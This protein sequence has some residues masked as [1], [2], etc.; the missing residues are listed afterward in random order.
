M[1]MVTVPPLRRR[2]GDG[3]RERIPQTYPSR[4]PRAFYSVHWLNYAE[5]VTDFYGDSTE[6]A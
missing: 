2:F 6:R 4:L 3:P 1:F 5:G